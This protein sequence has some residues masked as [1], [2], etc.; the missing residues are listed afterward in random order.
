ME[1]KHNT[2]IYSDTIL[3]FHQ[4]FSIHYL[5][6]SHILRTLFDIRL[7][8]SHTITKFRALFAPFPKLQKWSEMSPAPIYS[9]GWREIMWSKVSCLRKQHN[10]RD[11]ASNHLPSDTYS[12][13]LTPTPAFLPP[14]PREQSLQY[15]L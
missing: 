11:W 2:Y 3:I 8:F 9:P 13:A 12:K 7:Q 6:R 1:F 5:F 10:D 4:K 15:R 14:S